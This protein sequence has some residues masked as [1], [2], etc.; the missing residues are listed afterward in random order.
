MTQKS[1]G[2]RVGFIGA[3]RM[4]TALARGLVAAKFVPAQSIVAADVSSDALK[5]FA[6][7]TGAP[8]TESNFD[9]LRDSDVIVLSVKPQQMADVLAEIAP[10]AQQR[11]LFVSIAA[12][13][14]LA[15]LSR[16]LGTE[17]RLIRVM[18]NTPCLVAS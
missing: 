2:R 13:I 4:A 5:K 14:P 10:K 16:E 11:H 9:V 18:P 8:A 3:G 12:G 15:F 6:A 17:H 7:E 1:E